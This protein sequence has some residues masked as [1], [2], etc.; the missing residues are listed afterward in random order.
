MKSGKEV[1]ANE[2]E[3]SGGHLASQ[4]IGKSVYNGTGNDAQ[5]IGDVNDLVLGKDGKVASVVVGVGGFLGMGQKNVAIDYQQVQWQQRNGAW[6]IVVPTTADEL[7]AL[8]DFDRSAYNAA[9]STNVA[10]NGA[11]GTATTAPAGGMAT[12]DKGTAATAPNA[13]TGQTAGADKNATDT[14]KTAAIDRNKL[15]KLD[16]GKISANDL[17]GTTVYGADDA[18]VGSIKDVVLDKSGKIDAIVIDV[19]GFLGVGA[20]QVA[21]GMDNLAFLTDNNGRKYLYTEFT[22]DQLNKQPAYDKATYAQNRDKMRM[23]VR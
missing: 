4:L 2:A 15:D 13:G 14:N 23:T 8:P 17:I 11:G 3:Q 9:P 7:K 21:V 10:N 16:I 18:N 6:N 22:K 12:A 5:N 20:K 1:K 19:G